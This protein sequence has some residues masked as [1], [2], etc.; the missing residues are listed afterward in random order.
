MTFGETIRAIRKANGLSQRDLAGRV[1]P[2]FSYLSKIENGKLEFTGFPSEATIHK[3]AEALD[4][5]EDELLILA[6][7]VPE[8][9]RRLILQRPKVF[10]KLATLD[11][12]ALDEV[13]EA[14]G[15]P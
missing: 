12:V 13:L 15:G 11:D 9:V 4:A 2:N 14:I 8:A 7:K 6:E 5:D 3:L 10:R 1:G